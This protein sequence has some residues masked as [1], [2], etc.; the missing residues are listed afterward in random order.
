MGLMPVFRRHVVEPLWT[1]TSG[2]PLLRAASELEASQWL[3]EGEVKCHQWRRLK[4]LLDFAY[5]QNE[6][7]RRRF[8]AAGVVPAAVQS[9][10]DFSRIPVLTKAEV[11]AEG[12]GLL[13]RGFDVADLMSA[14]T[15][16]S[17]G[18]PLELWFTEEVS[19]LRNAS[20]RRHKRWSGWKV[21]EPVGAIWG[22]PVYPA[23]IKG[24]LRE[25]LLSPVIYLDTMS[26]TQQ[27][28]ERFVRD[29]KRV[30]PTMI[31]GHAHSVYL[32]ARLLSDLNIGD[33][34]PR[35]VITSSMMLLPHERAT[36]ESVF[37]ARVTDMYGC[38]EVGLIASECERHVGLH[39]NID[40]LV[41]EVLRE[42]G[43][44]AAPDESGFVVVTDLL[45]RA[46]P[47]IRYRMEDMAEV[48]GQP[49]S[50]GRGMPLLRRITGR[51]ADFLKRHDGSRV[52]GISLIENSLTR[53]PG[54]EQMQIVQEELDRICLK[55]VPSP[56]F[57]D[58]RR[59]ELTA[60]FSETFP[61]AH[62]DLEEVGAIPPEPNGKYR[63]SICR[64]PD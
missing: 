9:L 41:V 17:T 64:V 31:F 10:G 35:G 29:W 43:T 24:Q 45:N 21:G 7:Y 54:L 53:I 6:Y 32:F 5:E 11:R 40:Q 18:K 22:N 4:A 19:Q 2:A 1:W 12:R 33:V 47:F 62:V 16:G 39:A 25:W 15:G 37:G 57:S 34:R 58:E 3:P 56:A 55:V 61:G 59:R 38:E 30:R 49:C 8:G 63:F 36:I 46:M 50:C 26:V 20:G 48:A 14:K 51:V 13:S 27:A 60:Y 23:S 28:V 42:D 52:A 44:P